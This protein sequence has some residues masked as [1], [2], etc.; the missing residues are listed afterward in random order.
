MGK[1]TLLAHCYFRYICNVSML[2]YTYEYVNEIFFL[3]NYDREK[4][5]N[6][7]VNIY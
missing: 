7:I 6:Y 4:N 2:I 3:R 1:Y 5:N